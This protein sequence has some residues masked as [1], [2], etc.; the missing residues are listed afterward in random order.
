MESVVSR[1]SFTTNIIVVLLYKM[2]FAK[3]L[4]PPS[5][6][7]AGSS[8]ITPSAGDS[9][10]GEGLKPPIDA[11]SEQGEHQVLGQLLLPSQHGDLV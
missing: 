10:R 3:N 6:S 4:I 2:L 5:V 1:F 8:T 7:Q 11:Y 9:V